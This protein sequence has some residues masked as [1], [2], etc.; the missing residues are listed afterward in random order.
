M[1]TGSF[2]DNQF[3]K[4]EMLH[5]VDNSLAA[6]LYHCANHKAIRTKL[7]VNKHNCN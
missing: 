5:K 4:G 2:Y 3:V 1:R 6:S 7:F